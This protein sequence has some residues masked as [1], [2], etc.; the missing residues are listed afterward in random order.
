M[1]QKR[2]E[3]RFDVTFVSWKQ[4][5]AY[6]ETIEMLTNGKA[7]SKI[8]FLE[9]MLFDLDKSR[10]VALAVINDEKLFYFKDELKT[11]EYV[12]KRLQQALD[13]VKI[14]NLKSKYIPDFIIFYYMNRQSNQLT[15]YF[16]ETFFI[17]EY[18]SQKYLK[19]IITG[20]YETGDIMGD[21]PENNK[22]T[23][24]KGIENVFSFGYRSGV[25]SIEI[26]RRIINKI[27]E[28]SIADDKA[29]L[30]L[31]AIDFTLNLDNECIMFVTNYD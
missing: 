7:K 25:V 3:L 29:N 24:C 1:K 10:E 18:F 17:T 14:N 2:K 15:W 19:D 9:Q 16:Q 31:D 5:N 20:L 26:K 28:D 13:F 22:L 30:F 8:K 23:N 4:I 21:N 6:E 11:Y 27:M 12:K